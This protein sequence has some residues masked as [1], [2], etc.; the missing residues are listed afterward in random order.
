MY[1]FSFRLPL[2]LSGASIDT[3]HKFSEDI[4]REFC[5]RSILIH[6]LGENFKILY[7]LCLHFQLQF[8]NLG[9]QLGLLV[10]VYKELNLY[11]SFTICII[12]H[13]VSLHILSM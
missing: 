6:P 10:F 5:E 12:W 1:A 13:N 7:L 9:F 8:L 2:D 11:R 3:F 4:R